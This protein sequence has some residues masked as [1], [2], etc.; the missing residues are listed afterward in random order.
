MGLPTQHEAEA[1][2]T[3]SGTGGW[4]DKRSR[5]GAGSGEGHTGQGWGQTQVAAR[6]PGGMK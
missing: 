1:L 3:E 2:P 4:G 5:C 6:Q